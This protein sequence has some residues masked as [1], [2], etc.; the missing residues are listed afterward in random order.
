MNGMCKKD[1]RYDKANS[2]DLPFL[3]EIAKRVIR[4]N[5][6][7]FL[8]REITDSFIDS[9][10]SD[11]EI[12]VNIANCIIMKLSGI[13]IGF[14]ILLENKIHLIMIDVQYQNQSHGTTFLSY[15][16]TQLFKKYQNIEL[17]T[18]ANNRIA[19]HFYLKNNWA[20]LREE[21]ANMLILNKIKNI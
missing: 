15:L 12:E 21:D 20:I 11:N 9:G 17:Q 8:G 19:K 16:E 6:T 2:C 1:Y 4:N 3:K 13:P 7:P 14:G 5:Y 18:F 10:A